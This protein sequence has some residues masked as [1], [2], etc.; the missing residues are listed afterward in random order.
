VNSSA[1]ELKH[2]KPR[3]HRGSWFIRWFVAG[4]RRMRGYLFI[5]RVLV[6]E[7]QLGTLSGNVGHGLSIREANEMDLQRGLIDLPDELD[8]LFIAEAR[9]RGDVCLAAFHSERMIA[10]VWR[11]F[12]DAPHVDGIWVRID[13]PYWYTYKMY[14][15]PDFRGQRLSGQLTLLGDSVCADRG[16]TK[17]VGFIEIGNTASMRA[18]LRLG[19]RTI[20]F[21]G[22]LR[23]GGCVFPFRTPGVVASTFRFRRHDG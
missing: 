21:A 17:G 22:Y 14:S 20:G 2:Q 13:T 19:S 7:L 10:F 18:N 23:L 4:L 12:S 3:E 6:R 5:S 9:A 16:R 1:G 15:H 11:S 8:P